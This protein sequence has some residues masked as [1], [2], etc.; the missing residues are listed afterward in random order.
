MDE[1]PVYF[2]DTVVSIS[3]DNPI[4]LSYLTLLFGDVSGPA[5]ESRAGGVMIEL[6]RETE[7]EYVIDTGKALYRGPLGVSCAAI[8]YDLVILHL[9]FNAS[10]GLALH[11]GAVTCRDKLLLLPGQSGSGKSSLTAW[12]ASRGC[13]YLTDELLLLPS[14]PDHRVEYFTRPV[15]LKPDVLPAV[16]RHF[17]PS[18]LEGMLQDSNGAIIPHRSLS[19][20]PADD[21]P[22]WR[23]ILLPA[24]RQGASFSIEQLPAAQVTMILMNCLANGRNLEDHGFGSIVRLARTMS[25]YRLTYGSFID[26][27]EDLCSWLDTL[28]QG[29]NR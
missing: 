19:P 18:L 17:N 28:N 22:S 29:G 15:C 27:E 8:L 9:L 20:A 10:G 24:Y 23:M 13:T 12:L 4:A 21:G 2:G 25:A 11:A 26:L 5:P 16:K 14:Q 6:R 1:Y 3:Y 7:E